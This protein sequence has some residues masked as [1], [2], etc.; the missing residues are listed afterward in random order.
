MVQVLAFCW[1]YALGDIMKLSISLRLG[2]F[3]AA[4]GGDMDLFIT[5]TS[6]GASTGRSGVSS[7]VLGVM[8]RYLLWQPSVVFISL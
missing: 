8:L 1:L 3:N 6:S 4:H 2:R 7:P 5:G